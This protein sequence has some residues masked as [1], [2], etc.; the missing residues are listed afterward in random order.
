MLLGNLVDDLTSKAGA[1][2]GLEAIA[3]I[4]LLARLSAVAAIFE[5]TPAEYLQAACRRFANIAGG[6]DWAGLLNAIERRPQPGAA[7]LHYMLEWALAQDADVTG[8][9]RA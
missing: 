5:E 2:A 8:A 7:A 9:S 3:D 4:G 6:D 1:A